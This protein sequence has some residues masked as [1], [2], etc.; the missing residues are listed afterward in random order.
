MNEAERIDYLIKTL[1]GNNARAFADKAGIR[2]DTLS[3][4]RNGRVRPSILYTRIL[5]AYP[6]VRKEWLVNGEGEPTN[7]HKEKSLL[8]AEIELLHKEVRRLATIVERL[9]KKV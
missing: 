7:E 9:E 6:D 3:R 2:T 8:L 5:A 4:A 1:E